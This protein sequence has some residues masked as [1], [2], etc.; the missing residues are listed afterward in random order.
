MAIN[1]PDAGFALRD[2][3]CLFVLRSPSE[4]DSVSA[5]PVPTASAM[6]G[7]LRGTPAALSA[8]AEAASKTESSDSSLDI[9]DGAW[10]E[11]VR[12]QQAEGLLPCPPRRTPRPTRAPTCRPLENRSGAVPPAA[13]LDRGLPRPGLATCKEPA[14]NEKISIAEETP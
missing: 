3:D 2:G 11:A 6:E 10:V 12:Q 14:V 8:A 9:V 7:L 5:P 4:E 1:C 13:E